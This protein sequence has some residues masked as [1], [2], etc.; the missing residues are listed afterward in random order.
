VPVPSLCISED[1]F[2]VLFLSPRH[3]YPPMKPCSDGIYR[4]VQI[5]ED[6]KGEF[7][8]YSPSMRAETKQGRHGARL[9][10]DRERDRVANNTTIY[11]IHGGGFC[12]GTPNTRP[13][14][15]QWPLP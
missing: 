3:V 4:Q 12:L 2:N 15:P 8:S 11:F 10:G 9:E 14:R 6:I 1:I 7:V 13:V 5:G